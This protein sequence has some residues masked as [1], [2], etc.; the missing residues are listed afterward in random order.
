[1]EII[2]PYQHAKLCLNYVRR[3]SPDVIL[4]YSAGGKDSLVLLDMA[5]KIFNRVFCVY[6][7]FVKDLRH[8]Q[9]FI[10]YAEKFDNVQVLQYSH[11]IVSQYLRNNYMTI[12]SP[13][14]TNKISLKQADMEKRA[15][16]ETGVKW[17][18]F[19][20]KMADGLTRRLEL[21]NY[22]FDSINTKTQKAFPLSHWTKKQVLSYIHNFNMP[23]PIQYSEKTKVSGVGLNYHCLAWLKEH[24][25]HDLRKILKVFPLAEQKILN[26]E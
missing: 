7:Y 16:K 22:Y 10:N 24:Y 25:P 19:G 15:R 5:R 1:M 20:N 18:L 11:W 17:M 21:T 12:V 23:K 8:V 13:K 4:F 9:P 3:Q 6:M 26:N 2:N 14:R